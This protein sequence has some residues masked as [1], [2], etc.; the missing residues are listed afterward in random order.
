LA[1]QLCYTR[2]IMTYFTHEQ[3]ETVTDAELFVEAY[4]PDGFRTED[5][6]FTVC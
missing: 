4:F 1:L 3:C 2:Y 6:A 5:A